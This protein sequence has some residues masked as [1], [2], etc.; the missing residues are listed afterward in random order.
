M[1]RSLRLAAI[2]LLITA[3]AALVL[4]ET[5]P[6]EPAQPA[7]AAP[8]PADT[9]K[10][11]E[12]KPADQQQS[13]EDVLNQLLKKRAENPV[14]DPTPAGGS[15]TPA[16]RATGPAVGVAPGAAGTKLRRE[17]QFIVS[18]RGRM[19]RAAGAPGTTTPWMVVLEADSSN[20]AD[21]PMYLMPC[22]MLEDM[23]SVIQQHGES[24]VFILS[25]QVYVYRNSNYLLP[26]LM[27]LAPQK[28]NL[29]P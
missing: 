1:N 2:A 4:A 22:Q 3:S 10:A 6:G 24:M 5:K 9:G 11:S 12:T 25:G 23:E 29:Q 7:P 26:T 18:R 16:T 13:A 21:P 8:A 19:V 27:K 28:A 20:L 14:I 15:K 17:G